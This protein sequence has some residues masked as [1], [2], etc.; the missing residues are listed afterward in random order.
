MEP[1][2]IFS[3]F[4]FLILHS[5]GFSFLKGLNVNPAASVPHDCISVL[6]TETLVIASNSRV[7][8]GGE[9][10]GRK[11]DQTGVSW[12]VPYFERTKIFAPTLRSRIF[13]ISVRW[14][15]AEVLRVR[16]RKSSGV[17]APIFRLSKSWELFSGPRLATRKFRFCESGAWQG[18]R[19]AVKNLYCIQN[20]HL[21]IQEFTVYYHF[22]AL[23]NPR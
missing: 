23:A 18:G 6:P 13:L 7:P 2:P 14:K 9:S 17:N 22:F 11:P 5:T 8:D 21:D 16:N 15:P 20:T 4:L 10:L 3:S 19:G 12:T 1:C